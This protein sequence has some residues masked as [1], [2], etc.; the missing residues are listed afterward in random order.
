M[1]KRDKIM[2]EIMS[3]LNVSLGF[4]LEDIGFTIKADPKYGE[5]YI[6]RPPHP[7]WIEEHW[8]GWSIWAENGKVG[9]VR[10]VIKGITSSPAYMKRKID[11]YITKL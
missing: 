7:G 6:L 3:K 4:N 10:H 2:D 11:N 1:T 5:N 8:V 9:N